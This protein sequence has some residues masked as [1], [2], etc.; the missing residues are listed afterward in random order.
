MNITEKELMTLIDADKNKTSGPLPLTPEDAEREACVQDTVNLLRHQE[1]TEQAIFNWRIRIEAAQRER[2]T[3][4]VA[5]F[6]C[7][8]VDIQAQI[9]GFNTVKN[10]LADKGWYVHSKIEKMF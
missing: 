3:Q 7:V 5:T 6:Y 4:I 9:K 1:N 2:I 10:D 8:N